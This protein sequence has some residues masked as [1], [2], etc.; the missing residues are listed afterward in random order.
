MDQFQ[1]PCKDPAPY[2]EVM[3]RERLLD[4]LTTGHEHDHTHELLS[5]LDLMSSYTHLF[6]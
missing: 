6:V 5:Y 2:Q 4:K 1:F 3:P